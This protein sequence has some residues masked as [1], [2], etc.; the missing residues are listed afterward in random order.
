[1]IHK[2][3]WLQLLTL[4]RTTL[5]SGHITEHCPDNCQDHLRCHGQ[6]LH[7]T[8]MRLRPYEMENTFHHGGSGLTTKRPM[9]NITMLMS[10]KFLWDEIPHKLGQRIDFRARLPWQEVTW[11]STRISSLKGIK[12]S[13]TLSSCWEWAFC[14]LPH[15][16]WWDMLRQKM[17]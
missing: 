14:C 9:A 16:S 10:S 8:V 4:H 11:R 7:G 13:T 17:Y 6:A 3:D 12:S 2:D 1:M 15:F 5:K